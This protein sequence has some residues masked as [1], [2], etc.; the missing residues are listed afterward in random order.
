MSSLIIKISHSLFHLLLGFPK[1]QD[2][3]L[4]VSRNYSQVCCVEKGKKVQEKLYLNCDYVFWPNVDRKPTFAVRKIKRHVPSLEGGIFC[5]FNET[6]SRIKLPNALED[7][8]SSVTKI[9]H[10]TVLEDCLML[11][12]FAECIAHVKL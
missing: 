9:I 3:L 5:H 7:N 12:K 10:Q 1:I 11:S 8:L 4:I 2:E 6:E